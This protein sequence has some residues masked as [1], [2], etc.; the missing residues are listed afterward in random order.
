MAIIGG[1]YAGMWT[2]LAVRRLDPGARIV[3]LEAAVCGD[4]P[5][6]RNAGFANCF[7]H[8]FDRLE[9][10]HGRDRALEL[11]D[12]AA[13]SVDAIGEFA[14]EREIE[15]GY[16][17]AG[18]LKVSTTPSQDGSW[19]PALRACERAGRGG[20]MVALDAAA[21]RER[22]DSPLFR[23]GALVPQG[24]SVQPA[25]LARGLRS[26]VLDA[27]V[28]L[29]EQTRVRRIES[30]S[31]DVLLETDDGASVRAGA[32]VLAINAASAG[33]APLRPRL[34]VTSTH[35]IVTEP[36]PDLLEEIGWTGGEC[37]S[38]ARRH[39]HYFRTTADGR[40]AF[41]WGGG[42][43]AYGARLGG[44]VE[45]DRQVVERLRADI[46][47][48]FP[49]LRGRRV[50]AAWG[51]PVDVSPT[52]LPGVGTLAGGRVHYVCGFTGNGVGP[53]HLAGATLASLALGHV[54]SLTRSALVEPRQPPVPREPARFI[55]GTLVRAAL[56]RQEDAEDRGRRAGAWTRIVTQIPERLG[57]H[58][59]R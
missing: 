12:L 16:R 24:A 39:L 46:L 47:R 29:A 50:D 43:L 44:R 26:A 21:V 58:V 28:T 32:A 41:G 55:G 54:D 53:A 20:E 49:G 11:C 40:I 51:G 19:L 22:C 9:A 8:L 6:G 30:R 34:A 23:Q 1:G 52:H 38:T 10:A 57:I 17:K 56:V 31:G 37:I 2:A 48:F 5:S 45:V 15:I 33:V 7:W 3:L 4:G 59:G 36:V 42:R 13:A 35:M 27:G 25:L 14:R 18:H